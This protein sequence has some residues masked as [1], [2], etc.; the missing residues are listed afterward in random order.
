MDETGRSNP[1]GDSPPL[2][3][4]GSPARFEISWSS[5]VHLVLDLTVQAYQQMRQ[6]RTA[7]PD[8]EEDTFSVRLTLDYLQPL[9]R[10][11]EP[12]L[13]VQSQV[14]AYT[15]AMVSGEISTRLAPKI[16]IELADPWMDYNRVY[17]AWEC[18]RVADRRVCAPE[19]RNLAAEYVSEGILR[20]I[21]EEYATGL[22][23][24]GMLGYVLAGDVGYIVE[25][26][27]R[28]MLDRHRT[29]HLSGGDHLQPS[30][31][32]GSFKDI[33]QSSHRRKAGAIIRLH[34][35]FLTFFA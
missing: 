27:N 30:S 28:S 2:S 35:L 7:N 26:I 34:H 23:D 31:T 6:D 29:R 16:D 5:F 33:Y 10:Q 15:A 18:K 32:V 17:F 22:D 12:L 9:A 20:F 13:I 19:D 11:S 4:S 1:H 14:P 8:W 21:D 24:A 25:D 3:A